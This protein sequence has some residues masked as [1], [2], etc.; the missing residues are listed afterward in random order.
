MLVSLKREFDRANPDVQAFIRI[1]RYDCGCFAYLSLVGPG[2]VIPDIGGFEWSEIGD[3][4]E[5]FDAIISLRMTD[6]ITFDI[7]LA[8]KP[9]SFKHV[10]AQA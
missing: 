9:K 5:P 1:H 4:I 2:T 6:N 7:G 3:D 8:K 10:E